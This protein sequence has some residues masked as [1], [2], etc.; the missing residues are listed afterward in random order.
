M[1]SPFVLVIFG[2]T[3][4]LAKNKLIPALFQLF[5]SHQLP[6]EFFIVGFSRRGLSDREF[7]NIFE[8]QMTNNM[9]EDFAK[10][11]SYQQGNFDEE[12]GYT[13][14]V[15]KL[16]RLDEKIGACITR[17]FYLATPPVNY[18][19]I[20]DNIVTTKLTI[21]ASSYAKA[22]EGQARIA[23]EKPF[24]KDLETARALDKKLGEIFEEKQI[25]RVDHYLGKETVQNILVFRFANGIF[26]PIW[27]NEYIDH[28]QIT[29]AEKSGIGMRGAFFDGVGML[30]DTGQ[31]HLMQLFASVAMDMPTSFS[32]EGVR[33]VRAQA[34]QSI[35]CIEP[36]KVGQTTVRGQYRGYKEEKNVIKDSFTETFV[37]TK[38]FVH[39]KR[40]SGVPFYMRAGKELKE[41]IVEINIVF[42]QTC[43]ILFKEIGCPEEGNVLTIRVQPDEGIHLK[44][45][46]K[47]P[48]SNLTLRTV[49]M[50][51][52]YKEQFG[53]QGL[54]AYEKIL[55]DIFAGDQILFNR[56]DELDASWTFIEKIEKGWKEGNAPIC[57]YEKG[58]WG[59]KEAK[60]LIEKDN[61]KW[62][63]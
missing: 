8:E 42:K 18:E 7:Q 49:D 40:F 21:C 53:T 51:F 41:N 24:G 38:F 26:E 6:N 60:E 2:A 20:L 3:G 1:N 56:S 35:E 28:V 44:M 36:E 52:S 15:S 37:A 59:P 19:K 50:H 48:G 39:S 30:A 4:D 25:F 43:H 46:A 5:I 29:L 63:E 57:T 31:N 17:I 27:N 54:K 13:E 22:A 14:L 12:N 55:L 45:I 11:L 47:N 32:K 16:Q 9:W 34:I 10:H 62:I 61:R 33:D 58:S 23:I